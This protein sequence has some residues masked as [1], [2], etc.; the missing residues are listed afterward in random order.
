MQQL[1][2]FKSD[3]KNEAMTP[4]SLIA[5]KMI[6]LNRRSLINNDKLINKLIFIKSSF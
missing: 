2:I 3:Y 5:V 6:L 1:A 4:C